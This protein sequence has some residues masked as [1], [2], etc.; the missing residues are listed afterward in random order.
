[1]PFKFWIFLYR[2]FFKS[3][4]VT[5]I[6]MSWVS[7][8]KRAPR[9][10]IYPHR[11]IRTYRTIDLGTQINLQISHTHYQTVGLFLRKRLVRLKI[12]C[13]F[14]SV[15]I[16]LCTCVGRYRTYINFFNV[17]YVQRIRI[18]WGLQNKKIT[19]SSVKLVCYKP[20]F[21]CGIRRAWDFFCRR[22]IADVTSNTDEVV[23]VL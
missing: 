1:M 4:F 6:P 14:V 23:D 2:A 13:V 7:V 11:A 17:L 16:T 19:I 20:L 10:N 18:L 22:R 5:W 21:F 15:F 8:T 9:I 3:A 12:L